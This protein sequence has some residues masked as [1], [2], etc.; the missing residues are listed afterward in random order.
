MTEKVDGIVVVP[1]PS[2]EYL[3]ERQRID[4]RDHRHRILGRE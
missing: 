2:R 3:N 1:E 4:Y